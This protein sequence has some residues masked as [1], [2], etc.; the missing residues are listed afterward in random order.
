MY[1]SRGFLQYQYVVPDAAGDVV[2]RTLEMLSDA[3]AASFLAV[4]K[5]FGPGNPGPLSFP[6]PGLDPRARHPR[7][8][9]GPGAAARRPR[10]AGGRGGRPR[11]PRQG[12]PAAARA[13]RRHVPRPRPVRRA[14]GASRSD[15]RAP[16]RPPTPARAA[17]MQDALGAVQSVLVLGGGSDIAL[18]H[19]AQA[20]RAP[21]PHRGARGPRSRRSSRPRSVNCVRSARRPSTSIAVR[22][23]ATPRSTPRSS[24]TCSSV[25]AT[26]TSRCSRS[27][28]WAT[29]KMPSATRPRPSTSP[30]PTTSA[31]CRPRCHSRNAC[32]SRVTARSSRCRRSRV[33]GHASRTSSTA[34]RRP[35]WTPSSR[36]SATAS[37]V[38][39]CT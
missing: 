9:A 11:V 3:R 18:R 19:V 15:A 5:R 10:R 4:L 16:V 32:A 28:C 31:W 12:L 2:R 17:L 20:R 6:Q 26:S 22:R 13:P 1:G 27:A 30:P 33:S 23:R 21:R 35:G 36:A 34:P 7:R 29:R 38:P 25:S 24:T 39:V 8:G 37:S 14:A